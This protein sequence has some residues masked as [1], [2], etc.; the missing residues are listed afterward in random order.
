MIKPACLI[1]SMIGLFSAAP[2]WA[3]GH[4]GHGGDGGH[5]GGHDG[6]GHHHDGHHH[7]AIITIAAW[8]FITV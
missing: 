8:A 1:L 4:G 2:L 5:H 3:D 7:G 6:G